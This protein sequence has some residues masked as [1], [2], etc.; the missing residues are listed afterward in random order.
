[1]MDPKRLC[2]R[3]GSTHMPSSQH[4]P[5]EAWWF[6]SASYST[7]RVDSHQSC[8]LASLNCTFSKLKELNPTRSFKEHGREE[9]CTG[10]IWTLNGWRRLLIQ[11]RKQVPTDIQAHLPCKGPVWG[12]AVSSLS[13]RRWHLDL[14]FTNH[15]MTFALWNCILLNTSSS[16]S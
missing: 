4:P 10:A 7:R 1:M 13:C 11:R 15:R 16:E 9:R 5:N 2:G 6:E 8:K 14:C 12:R 3:K